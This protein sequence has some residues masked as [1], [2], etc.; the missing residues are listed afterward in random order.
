MALI[1]TAVV[2]MLMVVFTLATRRLSRVG[3]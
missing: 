2:G 3:G 1:Q